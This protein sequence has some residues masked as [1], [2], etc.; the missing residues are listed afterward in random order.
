MKRIMAVYDVSPF[1]SD[2]FA[3]FA[4]RKEK[5][6]FTVAAFTS[7]EKLQLFAEQNPIELLLI[8]DSVNR[9]LVDKLNAKQVVTLSDGEVV[10]VK[11]SYPSVYKYQSTDNVIREVMA[12]YCEKPEMEPLKTSLSR[13]RIIAVYSPLGRCLKTSFSLVLGQLMAQDEKVLYVNLEPYSG[14]SSI[15]GETFTGDLSD[16]MYMYRQGNY[17]W[18][19]LSSYV[20]SWGNLDYIPPARYPEDLEETGAQGAADLIMAI[21]EESAYDV[22]IVDAGCFGKSVTG[23]LEICGTIYMP[24]KDDCMSAAKLEEFEEYLTQS[25]KAGLLDKIQRLKLPYHSN[26]GRRD[27]YLEQLLWGELGDYVRQLLKGKGTLWH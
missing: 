17:H 8:S 24:V 9:E 23:I 18:M 21:A 7:M 14:F 13:C 5:V 2:R 15:T 12:C 22:I 19:K 6:P 26:F 16:V 11:N 4:N 27:T 10:D 25:G 3:D 20:Y 1:Y